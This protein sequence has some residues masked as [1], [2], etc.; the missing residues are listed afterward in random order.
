MS[1]CVWLISMCS[2]CFSLLLKNFTKSILNLFLRSSGSTRGDWKLGN[3]N[4]FKVK[5]TS[6]PYTLPA[7]LNH[8]IF[9]NSCGNDSKHNALIVHMLWIARGT[10]ST[11]M[12]RK[13]ECQSP[14]TNPSLIYSACPNVASQLVYSSNLSNFF[15]FVLNLS[16]MLC[17]APRFEL[18]ARIISGF[19]LSPCVSIQSSN[20]HKL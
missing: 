16:I 3:R 15:N 2:K 14:Y 11:I 6:G 19:I 18:I 13:L 17:F 8:T 5:F 20:L 1:L 4:M 7:L 10:L 12:C 9:S